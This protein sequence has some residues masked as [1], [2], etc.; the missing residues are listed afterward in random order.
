MHF[1]TLFV[2]AASA[3]GLTNAAC[4]IQGFSGVGCTGSQGA[5]REVTKAGRCV[6]FGG[7]RS[8]RLSADCKHV[9][10]EEWEVAS[11]P[12][13]PYAT[14]DLSGETCREINRPGRLKTESMYVRLV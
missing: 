3:I 9:R 4:T 12:A 13:N 10:K 7:R 8:F 6:S 11:C 2:L 1:Q 14:N 5:L